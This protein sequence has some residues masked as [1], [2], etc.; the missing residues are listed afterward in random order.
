MPTTHAHSTRETEGF[1]GVAG[2]VRVGNEGLEIMKERCGW[3]S[4]RADESSWRDG[5]GVKVA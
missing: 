4:K 1:A 2:V 3:G 5:A